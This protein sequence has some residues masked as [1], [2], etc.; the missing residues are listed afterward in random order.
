M[1]SGNQATSGNDTPVV[2]GI[3]IPMASVNQSSSFPA[4]ANPSASA[5]PLYNP[6]YSANIHSYPP[7]QQQLHGQYYTQ[8]PTQQQMNDAHGNN[9]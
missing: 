7:Q 2:Q 8:A 3:P 1:S 4:T 9:K 5:P 6:N